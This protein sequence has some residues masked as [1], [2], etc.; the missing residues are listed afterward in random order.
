MRDII[1]IAVVGLLL[2][3]PGLPG[4]EESVYTW[5]DERG[6]LNISNRKP[7]DDVSV[8]DVI[9]YK[10]SE[11]TLEKKPASKNVTETPPSS[12]DSEQRQARIERAEREAALAEEEAQ[13]A[14]EYAEKTRKLADD[15]RDKI[16]NKKKMWNKNK[17]R[18]MALEKQAQAAEEQARVAEENIMKARE[19][20]IRAKEGPP[21]E[22]GEP[23][24]RK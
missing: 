17:P 23:T 8:Q 24:V 7:K 5:T 15:F 13:K 21:A 16:G 4:A 1:L 3:G 2:L 18:L 12:F 22:T 10:K 9:R 19:R 20:L 11:T 14:R 6:V